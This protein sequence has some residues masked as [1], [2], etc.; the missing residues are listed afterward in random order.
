MECWIIKGSS[1]NTDFGSSYFEYWFNEEYGFVRMEW[2][3]YDNQKAIFELK[4]V[5]SLN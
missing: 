2:I 4:D 1:S 5:K 3:S